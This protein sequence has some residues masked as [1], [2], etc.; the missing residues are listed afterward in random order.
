[1]YKVGNLFLIKNI[2]IPVPILSHKGKFWVT[3]KNT[4]YIKIHDNLYAVYIGE[5]KNPNIGA[6]LIQNSIVGIHYEFLIKN[7]S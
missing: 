6:F 7:I 2:Y 4:N 1:M 3:K 5:T